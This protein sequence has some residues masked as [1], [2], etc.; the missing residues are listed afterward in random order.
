M[1][2]TDGGLTAEL[3]GIGPFSGVRAGA[4]LQH[5]RGFLGGSALLAGL[6]GFGEDLQVCRA[7]LGPKLNRS[8]QGWGP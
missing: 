4:S 1:R 5:T 7:S 2:C 6:R 3:V 8:G